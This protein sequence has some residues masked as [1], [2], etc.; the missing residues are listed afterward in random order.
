MLFAGHQSG[1][2]TNL[3][4]EA[5]SSTRR[6]RTNA[7]VTHKP[8]GSKVIRKVLQHENHGTEKIFWEISMEVAKE[9]SV[10]VEYTMSVYNQCLQ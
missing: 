6:Y 8:G 4:S 1:F 3:E 5:G 7:E 10:G 9:R 2:G